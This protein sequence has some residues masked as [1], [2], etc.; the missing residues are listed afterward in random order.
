MKRRLTLRGVSGLD[1]APLRLRSRL[2]ME[3]QSAAVNVSRK[4]TG[5]I[6]AA[7]KPFRACVAANRPRH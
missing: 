5:R 3:W 4:I 2:D 7:R 6:L 1:I